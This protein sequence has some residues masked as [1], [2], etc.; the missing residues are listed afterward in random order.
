MV[1]LNHRNGSRDPTQAGESSSKLNRPHAKPDLSPE[2]ARIQRRRAPENPKRSDAALSAEKPGI[3]HQIE[4]GSNPAGSWS[5][6]GGFDSGASG[7]NPR[8]LG[9]MWG[10]VGDFPLLFSVFSRMRC[11]SFPFLL[12]QHRRPTRL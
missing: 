8:I 9:F 11:G 5:A 4:H 1:Y 3:F 7:A 10:G 6:G 2:H 12:S